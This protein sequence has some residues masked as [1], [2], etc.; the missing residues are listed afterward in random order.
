M[1]RFIPAALFVVIVLLWG[2]YVIRKERDGEWRSAGY[3]MRRWAGGR[4]EYRPMTDNENSEQQSRQI[5]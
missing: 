2:R 4:W 5:W 3:K 1:E